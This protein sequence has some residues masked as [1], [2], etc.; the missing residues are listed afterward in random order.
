MNENEKIIGAIINDLMCN[1]FLD[2]EKIAHQNSLSFSELERIV[3]YDKSLMAEFVKDDL[4]KWDEKRLEISGKGKFFL[5]NIAS[6]FDPM[7]GD[8]NK[9]FSKT[10]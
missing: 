10:I 9:K 2:L 6:I 8:S 5:R 3:S 7:S 1:L 4:I